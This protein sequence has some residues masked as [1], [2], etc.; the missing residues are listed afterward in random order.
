MATFTPSLPRKRQARLST[1]SLGERDTASHP[2]DPII[3]CTPHICFILA[4]QRSVDGGVTVD[5]N[6]I[7]RTIFECA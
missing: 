4:R 7:A 2:D 1:T 5:D 6:R 3:V